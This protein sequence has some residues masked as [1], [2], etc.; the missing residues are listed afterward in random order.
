MLLSP[1]AVLLRLNQLHSLVKFA[2][3]SACPGGDVGRDGVFDDLCRVPEDIQMCDFAVN[4]LPD[5]L[6]GCS[7]AWFITGTRKVN[8]ES[9]IVP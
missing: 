9:V 8:R 3:K 7:F 4:L 1:W 5:G 6:H 2:G